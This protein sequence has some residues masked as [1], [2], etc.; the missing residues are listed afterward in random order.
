MPNRAGYRIIK[1]SH[2]NKSMIKGDVR[3][4]KSNLSVNGKGEDNVYKIQSSLPSF[5]VGEYSVCANGKIHDPQ[6]NKLPSE[7][8]NL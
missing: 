5:W 6:F 8:H 3:G 7:I 2:E 1:T 4:A